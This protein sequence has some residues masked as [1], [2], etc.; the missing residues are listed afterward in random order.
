MTCQNRDRHKF[1]W[2]YE[3]KTLIEL[4]KEVGTGTGFRGL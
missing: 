3:R 4:G 1:P 2:N